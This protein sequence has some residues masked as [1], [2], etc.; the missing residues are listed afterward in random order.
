M[1]YAHQDYFQRVKYAYF[2]LL[3]K[4]ENDVNICLGKARAVIDS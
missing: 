3:L 2:Y 4:V 1:V